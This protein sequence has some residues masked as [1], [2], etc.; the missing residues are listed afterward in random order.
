MLRVAHLGPLPPAPSGIA[1]Y[2]AELLP[3]LAGHVELEL[4]ALP[5]LPPPAASLA[6]RFPVRPLAQ[7]DRRAA[8]YDALLY[9]L[10]NDPRFHG[11]LWRA[12]PRHPGV[13]VLHEFVLHHMVREIT[14]AA[15]DPAGYVEEMRYAYGETGRAAAR[16]SVDTGV[17]LDPW[18][19]PLFERAADA[20]TALVTHNRF[21]RRRVLASRPD[22]DVAVVP[23][24]LSLA[25]WDTERAGS[26]ARPSPDLDSPE[27]RDA[28]RRAARARLGLP[29]D[30][31]LVG[32]FGYQNA[33]KRLDAALAGFARARESLRRRE[34]PAMR[35][36]VVGGVDPNL[37]LEGL[38]AAG[39]GED[40]Q[41]VGRVDD[42]AEFLDWMAAVDAAVNL[43]FPT[44]G[45]T[46]GT[47]IR[48]LGLG[49]PL[50]VS[51]AG[52]FAEI[53]AGCA[54][55]VP[56]GGAEVEV[57]AA[58]LVALATDP[59]LR[60]DLGAEARAHAVRHHGLDASAA[61]YA[62][63]LRRV[64]AAGRRPAP[65]PPP[66]APWREDDLC[67][68]LVS[69]LSAEACDLGVGPGDDEPLDGL[70]GALVELGL[71]R[72][73]PPVGGGGR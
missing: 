9:H 4:I 33:A 28:V 55:P 41:V 72:W 73:A 23:H 60:R 69:R 13:V 53:P 64:A 49:K 35:L 47:V 26:S 61:G 14:L 19:Y 44:A 65:P 71:D 10:G 22:A 67:T 1:D 58:A 42:L 18:T 51:D 50:L 20:A 6:E 52:S 39:P 36:L 16:R 56:T 43:R 68:G 27:G 11:P 3:R 46:S 59:A 70:S 66:L 34:M 63:V 15:G 57:L 32:T 37:D 48:L 17:P 7:L 54:V 5:G 38:S 29:A 40:V 45:E 21:A 31:F 24:H 2:A 12:L 25:P 8:D 62:A 30:A